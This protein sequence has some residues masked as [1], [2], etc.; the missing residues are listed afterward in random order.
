VKLPD[1]WLVAGSIAQTVW[2]AKFGNEA[3][4]GISDI[5]LVHFDPDD[6][7][8]ET[9]QSHALRI[10]QMF[11]ELQ[12]NLDVKNEARVYLWYANGEG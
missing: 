10:K 7:S 5:D 3:A 4:F 11:K 8:A 6:L 12:I 9:E 1:C 2:N